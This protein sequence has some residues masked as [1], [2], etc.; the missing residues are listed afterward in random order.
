MFEN[1]QKPTQSNQPSSTPTQPKNW[2]PWKPVSDLG[3]PAGPTPP[4]P[5]RQATPVGMPPLRQAS[6][7]GMPPR[8]LPPEPPATKFSIPSSL[9]PEPPKPS[10]RKYIMIS[11]MIFAI[12][13]VLIAGAIL[14]LQYV[15]NTNNANNENTEVNANSEVNVNANS[16]TNL[17][18]NANTNASNLNLNTNQ[19]LNS[20]LNTNLNT[21]T[22]AN[23]N[24]N[25]NA[26]TNQVLD[27]DG[28]GLSDLRE[29]L[30]DADPKNPDTDGDGYLDGAEVDAGYNP[31][32]TGKLSN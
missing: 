12:L 16:N 24:S 14:I 8:E 15:T 22:A 10:K 23:L 26:N 3:R 20:N 32:G 27:S 9:P 13:A 5:L 19:A 6:P 17:N 28:D 29:K 30:Y 7:M 11:L 2:G 4:P 1:V 21:N 18:R 25:A 31:N